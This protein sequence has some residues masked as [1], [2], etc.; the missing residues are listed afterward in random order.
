MDWAKELDLEIREKLPDV[1]ILP[2][3]RMSRH[4]SFHIG[5]PA[6]RMAFPSDRAELI[7]LVK[8]GCQYHAR[9]LIIG[10]GTNLLCPDEGLDRLVIDT[11]EN[12]KRIEIKS[13][14]TGNNNKNINNSVSDDWDM[15]IT[16][17]AGVLLRRLAE[18]ACRHGR[19]G[20]EFAHGIPGTVGGAV[21]MNAGA[22]GGEMAQVLYQAE[23]LFP[24]DDINNNINIKILDVKDLNLGYRHSILNEQPDAVILSASVKLKTGD[25]SEIRAKMRDLMDRRKKSQPLDLPSAGSTFKRPAGYFAG[26][27][28]D[29]CGLKGLKIGGAC[30]SE[31][32]AGFIVNQGGA[33]FQDVY[34]LILEVRRRVW[35]EKGV[36]LE[37]EVKIIR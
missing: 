29:Q 11:S 6:K 19:T 12:M 37:P 33:T 20:L 22:Y 13:G 5:G 32:H 23:I 24:D 18:F 21:C 4:T 16:A 3:E 25:E 7:A 8:L 28:I 30:V 2:M 36:R 15:I 31:K 34:G 27:L 10:N 1:K 17:D 9:P 26:T 35:E 14:E